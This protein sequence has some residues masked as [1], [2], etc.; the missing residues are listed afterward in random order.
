M[1][2]EKLEE[3][4]T[5]TIQAP[6]IFSPS[7]DSKPSSTFVNLPLLIPGWTFALSLTVN[8]STPERRRNLGGKKSRRSNQECTW[9]PEAFSFHRHGSTIPSSWGNAS[10]RTQLSLAAEQ[11]DRDAAPTD[12]GEKEEYTPHNNIGSGL[13]PLGTMEVGLADTP[14]VEVPVIT[15]CLLSSL[16]PTKVWLAVTISKCPFANGLFQAVH[17]HAEAE[18]Q[19][20]RKSGDRLLSRSLATGKLFDVK[21]LTSST[22]STS[23]N[24]GK[25]L[26]TYASLSVLEEHINLSSG[27]RR[28][29]FQATPADIF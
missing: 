27:Q 7:C 18:T 20:V 15:P 14:S 23:G 29:F 19:L 4:W 3:Q 5:T 2:A 11:Y 13:T 25:F 17:G 12:Y 10:M 22:C 1:I 9:V 28:I 6:F 26:P 16:R 8:R 21:F 24:T